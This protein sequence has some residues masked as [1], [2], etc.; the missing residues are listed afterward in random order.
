MVRAPVAPHHRP[1]PALSGHVWERL[2]ERTSEAE[3]EKAV[4]LAIAFSKA[5]PRGSHAVRL[6]NLG[7]QRGLAWQDRSNG[8]QVW[9][10]VRGGEVKTIMLRRS[11]QPARAAAF[12]VDKVHLSVAP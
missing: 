8:D 10:I 12:D 4:A 6:M 1:S 11:T 2:L 5:N 7:K 3:R 9:A